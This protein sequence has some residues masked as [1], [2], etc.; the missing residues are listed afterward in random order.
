MM[1]AR[2]LTLF[3][4]FGAVNGAYRN[5]IKVGQSVVSEDL[6]EHPRA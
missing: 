4:L 2:S 6:L 1:L 5:E 3:A